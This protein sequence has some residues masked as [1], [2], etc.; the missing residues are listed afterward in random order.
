VQ[1]KQ[2]CIKLQTFETI[3]KML[4]NIEMKQ[5]RIFWN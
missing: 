2:L 5:K 3:R 1:I 4:K